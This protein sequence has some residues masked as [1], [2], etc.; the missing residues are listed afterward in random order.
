[1]EEPDEFLRLAKVALLQS[2]PDHDPDVLAFGLSLIR[3]GNRLQLDLDLTV[4]RPAGVSWAAYRVLFT[5]QA[6]GAIAPKRLARL[7]G[8]TAASISSVLR[9]LE[10]ADLIVREPSDDDG[11]SYLVALSPEGEA[12][13]SALS[14]ANHR[15][16][17]QW[18]AILTD[19]ER[20]AVT[21]I[22]ERLLQA[23]APPP[24]VP[25]IS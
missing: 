16:M 10:Q 15:R 18:A 13:A 23:P 7:A 19:D 11:R 22:V 21:A 25:N 9:T 8:T 2:G 3:I 20:R 14:V 6:V 4:N 1:M 5:V 24:P 17:E 12:L